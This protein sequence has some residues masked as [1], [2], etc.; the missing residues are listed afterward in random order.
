MQ[1]EYELVATKYLETQ[2]AA[3]TAALL[4]MPSDKVVSI[5]RKP[6]VRKFLDTSFFDNTYA[7]NMKIQG[8]L[9]KAIEQ[10]LEDALESG[11]YSKKDL[12]DLLELSHKMRIAEQKLSIERLK[13]ETQLA[14]DERKIDQVER[15]TGQKLTAAD[16]RL[17]LKLEHDKKLRE[18]ETSAYTSLLERLMGQV[19]TAERVIDAEEGDFDKC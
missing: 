7:N 2:D 18:K 6:S 14:M 10:K 5:L 15:L 3:K 9:D 4:N 11:V 19:P 17:R 8:V 13:L 1:P 16:Q 12:A